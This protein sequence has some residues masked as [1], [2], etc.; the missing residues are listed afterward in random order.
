MPYQLSSDV[1][2]SYFNLQKEM[3]SSST[4][5]KCVMLFFPFFVGICTVTRR[6]SVTMLPLSPCC[7]SLLVI[8]EVWVTACLKCESCQCAFITQKLSRRQSSVCFQ[9]IRSYRYFDSESFPRIAALGKLNLTGL[10]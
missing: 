3:T 4:F 8:L 5:L 2:L 10:K 1:T 6:L 9:F 7:T